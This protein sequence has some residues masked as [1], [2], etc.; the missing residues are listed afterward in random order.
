M[1]MQEDG[2]GGR[3]GWGP[4]RAQVGFLTHR[5]RVKGLQHRSWPLKAGGRHHMNQVW[6]LFLMGPS[7]SAFIL[8]TPKAVP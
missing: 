7:W 4:R 1:A 2:V 3:G 8:Q 6:V 5:K